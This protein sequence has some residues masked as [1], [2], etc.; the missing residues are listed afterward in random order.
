MGNMTNEGFVVGSDPIHLIIKGIFQ[1]TPNTDLVPDSKTRKTISDLLIHLEVD[2]T[3]TKPVGNI[4]LG[5]HGNNEGS[6][7]LG[8]DSSAPKNPHFSDLVAAETSKSVFIKPP[9]IDLAQPAITVQFHGCRIGQAEPF[10]QQLKK[11][12]GGNVLVSAPKVFDKADIHTHSSRRRGSRRV[13][14]TILGFMESLKYDYTIFQKDQFKDKAALVK[15]FHDKAQAGDFELMD[16]HAP[17]DDWWNNWIPTRIH[18]KTFDTSVKVSYGQKLQPIDTDIFPTEVKYSFRAR[19]FQIFDVP[20]TSSP[21]TEKDRKDLLRQAL[22]DLPESPFPIHMRFGY[23]SVDD[24]LDNVTVPDAKSVKL[25]GQPFFRFKGLRQEYNLKI[26]V[27][28]TAT[29][30]TGKTDPITANLIFNFYPLKSSGIAP[31]ETIVFAD[32]HLFRVL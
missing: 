21:K 23:D 18:Q 28:D 4:L 14:T 16:G 12:F 19:D 17:P 22:N 7:E 29:I 6:F 2:T 31:V 1:N 32:G 3:I 15:A 9:V 5:T 27:T 10:M 8:L 25:N 20:A 30:P 13:T 11:T 24:L 26:P